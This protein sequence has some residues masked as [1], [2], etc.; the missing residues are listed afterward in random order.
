MAECKPDGSYQYKLRDLKVQPASIAAYNDLE[1]ALPFMDL[2]EEKL[3]VGHSIID[4]DD[5]MITDER[6]EVGE[7]DEKD[8]FHP[9]HFAHPTDCQMFYKC[10][11]NRAFKVSCPDTLHFNPKTEACDYPSIVKCQPLV[12]VEAA[13]MMQVHLPSIPNCSHGRT[14]NYGLQGSLTR[15]FM[16]KNGEVYLMECDLNE[17]FNPNL[18]EC[19]LLN[20][21]NYWLS[22]EPVPYRS[23]Y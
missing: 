20:D 9:I 10:F 13:S 22:L 7:N 17:F 15:Y 21:Y 18:M 3:R 12:N 8:K 6:C 14:V 2:S 19:D 16:C 23:Y 4:D 11:N 5:Y 1:I